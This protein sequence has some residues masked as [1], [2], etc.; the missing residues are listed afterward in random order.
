MYKISKM[1]ELLRFIPRQLYRSMAEAHSAEAHRKGFNSWNQLVAMLFAQLSGVRSLRTLCAGFNGARGA[2][3]HLGCQPIKRSTLSDANARM[4]GK[5]FAQLACFL[6]RQLDATTREE[7]QELIYAID[8]SSIT[9]TGRHFDTW[10]QATRSRNNAGVKLHVSLE[11]VRAA[12]RGFEINDANV[13]DIEWA[14]TQPIEPGVFYSFDKGYCDYGWWA[15]IDAEGARFVTRLKR[16][17]GVRVERARALPTE[18]TDKTDAAQLILADEIIVFKRT[19]SRG[20]KTTGYKKPLRRITVARPEHA[21][22]TPL[23]LVTNDLESPATR[24]AEGYRERWQVELFF[25]WIKQHLEV[26]RFLG[27]SKQAVRIQ[28]ICA[29]IAYALLSLHKH[30]TGYA[31]TLWMLLSELRHTLFDA[32]TAHQRQQQREA[33]RSRRAADIADRQASLLW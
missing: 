21:Q 23:V 30:A 10:T 1:A 2:L 7:L 16:N 6:L 3:Y 19:H 9:L 14:R 22:Q 32:S 33:D 15:K 20:G 18:H 24:I 4:D 27:H 17:A 12:P 11:S 31:S 8:S 26:K 28:L 5:L 13:N 25:K 29:I